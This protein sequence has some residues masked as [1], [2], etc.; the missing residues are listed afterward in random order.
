MRT[1]IIHVLEEIS[2]PIKNLNARIE[3]SVFVGRTRIEN[4]KMEPQEIIGAIDALME[5]I[6]EVE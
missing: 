4:C 2:E 5:D 3:R 1:Y 6:K